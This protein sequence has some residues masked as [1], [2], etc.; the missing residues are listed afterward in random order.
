MPLPTASSLACPYGAQVHHGRLAALQ[1]VS[2]A[3][4]RGEGRVHRRLRRIG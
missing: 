2:A 1:G 4:H 3:L